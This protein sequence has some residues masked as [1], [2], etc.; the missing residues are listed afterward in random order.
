MTFSIPRSFHKAL[1]HLGIREARVSIYVKNSALI[2]MKGSFAIEFESTAFRYKRGTKSW[3]LCG[4]EN[5]FRERVVDGLRILLAPVIESEIYPHRDTV[6]QYRTNWPCILDLEFV[7]FY[8]S[9]CDI[10]RDR[11]LCFRHGLLSSK[12][13]T[14]SNRDIVLAI[15]ATS[16]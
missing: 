1:F 6:R 4:L 5:L 8:G 9:S 15:A 10:V 14:D 16:D 13:V 3:N 7:Y 12:S 2:C 11:R